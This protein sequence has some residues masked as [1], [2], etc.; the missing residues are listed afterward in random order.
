MHR[1]KRLIKN[2]NLINIVLTGILIF[3]VNYMVLPFFNMGV[4][5]T[6]PSSIIRPFVD[7]T[8]GVA[9]TP[10]GKAASPSDYAVIPELNFF[11]P[12]RKIPSEKKEAAPLPRP[13]FV[14]YG[15]LV[16]DDLNIAYME[17]KKAP[18]STPGREKRQTPLKTGE[19][20]SGFTLKEID[21][22]KV[23]MLR[24]EEKIVVYLNDAQR[25]KTRE[26]PAQQKATPPPP[27]TPPVTPEPEKAAKSSVPAER[28][29]ARMNFLDFIKHNKR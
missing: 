8:I 4:K 11:H 17:D 23:V 18:F 29:K 14:L 15:T 6:L 13:D 26:Q 10:E 24:D 2:I 28:D 25:P 7:E 5:Y 19:S 16:T 1:L 20:L 22:D 9:E 12:E 21:R 27:Q 3:F